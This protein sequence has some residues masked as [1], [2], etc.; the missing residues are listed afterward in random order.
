MQVTKSK[1]YQPQWGRAAVSSPP[2][3]VIEQQL[4]RLQLPHA[5]DV[6]IA[7]QGMRGAAEALPAGYRVT[8]GSGGIALYDG[9]LYVP[10][11]GL[12]QH[13][14]ADTVT[15]I[16]TMPAIGIVSNP[17]RIAACAGLGV[18]RQGSQVGGFVSSIATPG[19]VPNGLGTVEP[20][21]WGWRLVATG[22]NALFRVPLWATSL[23][24]QTKAISGAVAAEMQVRE[25]S[26]TGGVLIGTRTVSDFA[27]PQALDPSTWF[28][29]VDCTAAA[30]QFYALLSFATR[31]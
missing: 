4:V 14:F 25:V 19:N 15:V 1:S 6:A 8:V 21:A 7:F 20:S 9:Q 10:A 3:G 27:T 23:A 29:E 12:T 11:V 5:Q 26:F 22:N 13:Y 28:I 17:R 2:N 31:T 30:G 18:T 24:I 16:G